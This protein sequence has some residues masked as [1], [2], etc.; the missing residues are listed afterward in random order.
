MENRFVLITT[1]RTGATFFR[2]CLESHPDVECPGTLFAQKTRLK[3]FSTDQQC[4]YYKKYRIRTFS[5]HVSHWINRRTLIHGCLNEAY[6]N[7][8]ANRKAV[9]FKISYSNLERYPAIIDW[10]QEHDIK[11]LHWFRRNLVKRYVSHLTKEV[12]GKAHF[13]NP[14]EQVGVHVNL[15]KLRRDLERQ[16]HWI[17]KYRS[18]FKAQKCLEVF[19]ED[20][21][22]DQTNEART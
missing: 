14:A 11:V 2:T 21:V 17:E 5:N 1:Q 6:G 7:E 18:L 16:T 4:S 3:Y 20:F 22:T 10:L 19:Y 9:G 15:R 8:C 13:T 12:R